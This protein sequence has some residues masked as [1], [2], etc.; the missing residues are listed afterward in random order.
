MMAAQAEV[1]IESSGNTVTISVENAGELSRMNLTDEVKN[2]TSIILKGNLNGSDLAALGNDQSVKQHLQVVDLRDTYFA[3]FSGAMGNLAWCSNIYKVYLPA[4]ERMTAIPDG[5]MGYGFDGLEQVIIPGNYT[6]IGK[7]AFSG[8]RPRF[9]TVSIPDGVTVIGEGAFAES[10]LTSI[11]MPSALQRIESK[12]FADCQY[13]TSVTIPEGVT[14][15]GDEAFK[16]CNRLRDVY[17]LG[18]TAPELGEGVFSENTLGKVAGQDQYKVNPGET[19][20]REYY[21]E[22]TMENSQHIGACVLHVPEGLTPTQLEAYTNPDKH[23]LDGGSFDYIAPSGRLRWPNIGQLTANYNEETGWRKFGLVD[24]TTHDEVIIITNIKDDTWYT[25]VLPVSLTK[26][27]IEATFGAGTELC[28]FKDAIITQ[29]GG[30]KKVVFDFTEDVFDRTTDPVATVLEADYPYMIHPATA[31]AA[32]Q[33]TVAYRLVGAE[34]VDESTLGSRTLTGVTHNG[35]TYRGNYDAEGKVPRGWYFLGVY[36]GVCKYYFQTKNTA[37]P[38]V[39][40]KR[41]TCAIEP[42]TGWEAAAAMNISFVDEWQPNATPM[43][44]SLTANMRNAE[45][46]VAYTLDGRRVDA[47]RLSRGIYIIGGKKVVIK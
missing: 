12:A 3:E 4:D 11:R 14:Y 30:Q 13:L 37:K 35:F 26:D 40:W 38:Q 31:P 21:W 6:S 16:F 46:N 29:E 8:D 32:G 22:S 23:A 17:C 2:A 20:H 19:A 43:G 5:C 34:K 10:H 41:Y 24:Y 25:V 39:A 45:P 33:T 42:P 18:T 47:S 1:A 9:T 15:I 36:Q 7:Q 27:Q 28:R 44:I